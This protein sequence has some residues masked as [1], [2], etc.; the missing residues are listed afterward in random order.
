MAVI[1]EQIFTRACPFCKIGM[2]INLAGGAYYAAITA[3]DTTGAVARLA[4]DMSYRFSPELGF[5]TSKRFEIVLRGEID[6]NRYLPPTDVSLN[7]HAGN[8][9]A[10]YAG[11]WSDFGRVGV[12]FLGGYAKEAY[13]SSTSQSVLNMDPANIPKLM[14]E[15]NYNIIDLNSFH[16]MF[17]PIGSY[18]LK[19]TVGTFT[20]QKGYTYGAG[21]KVG[22][23]S[24]LQFW[25]YSN[26]LIKS[27]QLDWGKQKT[28]EL[29]FGFMLQTSS[30]GKG[31]KK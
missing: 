21:V 1:G 11:F 19:K 23:G 31:E 15:L 18:Y 10:Y 3:T 2:R 29:I 17:T 4:S 20:V 6:S 7:N 22:F 24:E 25:L 26:Y 27:F 13:L 16:F 5:R 9:F 8:T 12:S 14:L 28:S 30:R